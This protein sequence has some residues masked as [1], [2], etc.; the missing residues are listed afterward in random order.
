MTPHGIFLR[1]EPI[2]LHQSTS[3][4]IFYTF[5]FFP[6]QRIAANIN[7]VQ[8][9][10]VGSDES[11]RSRVSIIVMCI[12]PVERERCLNGRRKLRTYV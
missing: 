9:F 5:K 1:I 6:G 7:V 11:I 4:E 3:S 2:V 12:F 8:G 10:S